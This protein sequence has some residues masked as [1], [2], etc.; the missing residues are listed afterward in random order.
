MHLSDSKGGN[1]RR[2][3]VFPMRP[4]DYRLGSPESRAAARALLARRREGRNRGGLTLVTDIPRPGCA[5]VRIGE[6]R[7]GDD[8]T[9]MRICFLPTGMT[10][11]EAE[12]IASERGEVDTPASTPPAHDSVLSLDRLQAAW[13]VRC[14]RYVRTIRDQTR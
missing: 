6:L 10:M 11:E 4:G 3:Q 8:G 14:W 7:E 12:R 1:N 2:L 5:G 9:L 13:V